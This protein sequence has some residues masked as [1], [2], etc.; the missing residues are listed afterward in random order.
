MKKL[1]FISIIFIS[2]ENIGASISAEDYYVNSVYINSIK[3]NSKDSLLVRIQY[4]IYNSFIQSL[5]SK[6]SESLLKIS[7]DLEELYKVNNQN[8]ILYWRSYLQFYLSIFYIKNGDKETSEK[9]IDKGIDL[10]KRIKKKNSEDYALLARLQGFGIQFKGIRAMFISMSIKNNLKKSIKIDSTNLRA[11]AVSATNDY[12]TPKKY[13]GGKNV[14]KYLLKAL[15]LPA[16]K[17]KNDYLP[18]WGREESYELLIKTY[19]EE[20]KWDL[21]EKYF[22]NGIKEYPES[23]TIKQLAS[24]IIE[25]K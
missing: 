16:Q 20:K 24:K 23:Y 9:E 17:I 7:N 6:N 18:S 22:K 3:Q 10:L 19:I 11:Y 13:G 25:K 5:M 4:K 21:A 8:I 12:H 15:S 2:C 14:E 1:L